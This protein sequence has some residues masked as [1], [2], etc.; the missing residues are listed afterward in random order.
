PNPPPDS[1]GAVA[2]FGPFRTDAAIRV[3]DRVPQSYVHSSI[4]ILQFAPLR[5][6]VGG[7]CSGFRSSGTTRRGTDRRNWGGGRRP[8]GWVDRRLGD[9]AWLS[10]FSPLLTTR[11]RTMRSCVRNLTVA[12]G[13]GLA[14]AVVGCAEDN[15]KSVTS[16]TPGVQADSKAATQYN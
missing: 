11:N 16:A 4:G 7:I 2:E 8:G 6:D 14:V 9:G 12:A 13:L 1:L 10:S 5:R 3:H 15:Q